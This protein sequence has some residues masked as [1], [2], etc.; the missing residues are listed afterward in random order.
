M[1]MAM[2]KPI[3]STKMNLY[4]EDRG[5]EGKTLPR[6]RVAPGDHD[7]AGPVR[8]SHAGDHQQKAPADGGQMRNGAND[9]EQIDGRGQKSQRHADAARDSF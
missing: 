7:D 4:E 2:D 9:L 6:Q 8:R 5:W 1:I 3:R